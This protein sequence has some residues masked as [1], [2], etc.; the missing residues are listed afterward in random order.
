LGIWSAIVRRQRRIDI[1]WYGMLLVFGNAVA[2]R[3]RRRQ[4]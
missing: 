1:G 2:E 3:R 4:W